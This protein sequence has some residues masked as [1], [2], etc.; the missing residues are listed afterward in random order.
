M[1]RRCEK[2][3]R[4]RN[5]GRYCTVVKL[6]LC[7]A[8]INF[9]KCFIEPGVVKDLNISTVSAYGFTVTWN[10][11]N[12]PNGVIIGYVVRLQHHMVS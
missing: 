7:L 2:G 4:E 8:F 3:T 12:S 5:R 9:L 11:P 1:I 10:D 6:F